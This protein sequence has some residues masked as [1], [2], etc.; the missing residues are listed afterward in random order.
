[1]RSCYVERKSS[2]HT[3]SETI[4]RVATAGSHAAT[5][6]FGKVFAWV[7]PR[8]VSPS[9]SW[10]V[11]LSYADLLYSRSVAHVRIV[12]LCRCKGASVTCCRIDAVSC[13]RDL[14]L[15]T[16]SSG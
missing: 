8:G 11:P 6:G 12:M 16:L 15:L 2:K 1:M 3:Q 14:F 9:C 13:T 7:S 4:V 10:V 5:D